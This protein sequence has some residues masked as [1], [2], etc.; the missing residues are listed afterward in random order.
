MGLV[1]VERACD[2]YGGNIMKV[3]RNLLIPLVLAAVTTFTSIMPATASDSL[4]G[5]VRKD[6]YANGIVYQLS[7][8]VAGLQKQAYDLARLRLDEALMH[9]YEHQKPLAIVSDIDQTIMSDTTYQAEQLQKE[10]H[11]DNGPWDG[12]YKAVASEADQPIP[13][14]VAFF[15]YA[16]SQGVEVFYITNRDWDTLDL[17]VAQLKH[18]G[19]PYADAAHV[20]VMDKS[21][22]SNKD[23]RRENVLATHDVIMYLGDNI[24]DFT[25][26][27]KREY[28]AL[29]RTEMATSPEYYD[30]WG[31]IWIVL[32]NATYGDY[33]GAVW[34]NDKKAD[35]NEKTR[36]LLEHWRYTNPQWKTWYEGHVKD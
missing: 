21:G 26:A 12:Y 28:G 33:M 9:R 27:F 11:W 35:R 5:D 16:A 3:K 13:G 2:L 22:S 30:N 1:K 15:N 20:Q 32:P 6:A 36:E 23:A 19:L 10:G 14:A 34:N 24:G 31:T 7:A 25:S 17:T 18:A 4:T 8:E 29:K